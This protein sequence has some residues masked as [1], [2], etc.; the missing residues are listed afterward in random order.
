MAVMLA[1]VIRF[2]VL[3]IVVSMVRVV[4]GPTVADR[5][6]GLNLVAAQTL[7]LLV[8]ISVSMER[9]IY[10]DVA[11]VYD[12]FGFVGI[13]VMTRYFSGKKGEL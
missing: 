7:A 5:M 8:L 2:M 9:S 12:I 11:L 1:W 10:L 13:L 4:I 3:S 6:I